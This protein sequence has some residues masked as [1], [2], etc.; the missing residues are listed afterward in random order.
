[1]NLK[2]GETYTNIELKDLDLRGQKLKNVD[3]TNCTF[4]NCKFFESQII[5]SNL[6]NASF[7]GCDLSLLK[8]KGSIFSDV[9][10]SESKLTGINWTELGGLIFSVN[11]K[12]CILKDSIFVEMNLR[13]ARFTD[14]DLSDTDFSYANLVDSSF[15]GCDLKN[16]SFENTDLRG[17]DLSKATNYSINPGMNKI[18]GAKFS[19]PEVLSFLDY[20]DIKVE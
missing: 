1:M 18:K 10:F 11:F 16:A 8:I 14:C 5:D 12:K 17:A 7:D 4:T 2:S 13:D 6:E 20:L 15:E 9:L 3:F 19:L